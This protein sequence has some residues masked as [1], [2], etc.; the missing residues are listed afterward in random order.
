MVYYVG[1]AVVPDFFCPIELAFP[2]A[3]FAL[4]NNKYNIDMGTSL[5]LPRGLRN[6]N[7]LNIRHSS[8]K[9]QGKAKEQNDSAFVTFV[10]NAYGYRAAFKQIRTYQSRGQGRTIHEIIST[11]APAFE[12]HTQNYIKE[13][14]KMSGIGEHVLVY[15]SDEET[16]VAI[17]HAMAIVENGIKW[18]DYI[19]EEE[20]RQGYN[21]AFG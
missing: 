12:N 11:W 9:W 3:I 19:K 18:I 2:T 16:M 7:P 5:S 15:W 4:S 10:S 20:I 6:H 17:V 1:R 8:A 13:V 21:L 14:C